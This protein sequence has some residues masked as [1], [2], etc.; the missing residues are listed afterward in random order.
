MAGVL[1]PPKPSQDTVFTPAREAERPI[2]TT[3]PGGYIERSPAEVPACPVNRKLHRATARKKGLSRKFLSLPLLLL[4]LIP[5]CAGGCGGHH[6]A[7]GISLQAEVSSALT[8][9]SASNSFSFRLR[10]E[11][12][13]GVSG[14]TVYGEERGEG[15]LEGDDLTLEILR[16]SPEGEDRFT[17]SRREGDYFLLR[18]GLE[19]P[20]DASEVPGPLFRPREFLALFSRFRDVREEGEEER[21]GEICRVFRLDYDHS[22]A[23]EAL[24]PQAKEYFTNLDYELSGRLWLGE[25][26]PYPV[27]ISLELTGLD[28]TERLQ[29]LRMVFTFQPLAA[30]RP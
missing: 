2:P 8:E 24:P 26:S 23:L 18:D 11:T 3:R 21:E 6:P 30:E 1:L 16:I 10:M 15:S 17:I 29:R 22:L 19:R 20:A 4:A 7:A 27:A 12:W 14:Y 13:V 25:R 28:P 5:V 9:L